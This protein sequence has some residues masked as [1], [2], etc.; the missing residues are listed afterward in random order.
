MPVS[1]WAE[2]QRGDGSRSLPRPHT[3]VAVRRA[4]KRERIVLSLV[5]RHVSV[6][7]ARV[8]HRDLMLAPL[9]DEHRAASGSCCPSFVDTSGGDAS[10]SA[11]RPSE[12]S[13]SRRSSTSAVQ[14]AIVGALVRRPHVLGGREGGD[15]TLFASAGRIG[16]ARSPVTD[17][18]WLSHVPMPVA[19]ASIHALSV[20]P[21]SGLEMEGVRPPSG[22]TRPA[23]SSITCS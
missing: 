22:R 9:F 2:R 16:C 15:D 19:H 20:M 3:R 23:L 13:C 17:Q 10:H 14:Q 5:R 11:P 21:P 1:C 4:P 18:R 7:T 12:T 8:Q 6:V